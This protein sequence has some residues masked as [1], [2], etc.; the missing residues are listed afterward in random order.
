MK[1]T[2][3]GLLIIFITLPITYAQ[4]PEC[5]ANPEKCKKIQTG[6]PC[7]CQDEEKVIRKEIEKEFYVKPTA[8]ARGFI[9]IITEQK[10]GQLIIREVL[11]ESPAAEAGL[12]PGDI[13]LEINNVEVTTPME[14]VEFMKSTSPGDTVDLKILSNGQEKQIKIKLGKPPIPIEKKM[15]IKVKV[16]QNRSGGAGYFGPGFVSFDFAPINLIL[17]NHRLGSLNN[18]HWTFGGGGYGQIERIRI[19]GFGTGGAQSV[20]NDTFDI[21]VGFGA[22]FFELG[23][24]IVQTNHFM[25]TPLLGIGGGGLSLKRT[26]TLILYRPVNFD[27][28]LSSAGGVAKVSKGGF[29][30]SPG[31]AIDIP[32]GFTGIS[33]KGGYMWTV[34]SSSWMDE[35]IGGKING[36]KFNL[37]GVY[38]SLNVMFG[39]IK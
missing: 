27:D 9:G 3:I 24:S 34:L 17:N 11:P 16:N 26:P 33:I 4:C 31:L 28:I 1:N 7:N 23:Y 25:L 29:A 21:E 6:E 5:Q 19:G 39:G 12:I 15:Q 2:I 8:E 14:L 10:E 18:T 20:S 38:C 13:I 35:D 32:F 30:L 37:N 22:G 36:P